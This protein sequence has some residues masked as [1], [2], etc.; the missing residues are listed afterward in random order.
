MHTGKIKRHLAVPAAVCAAVLACVFPARAGGPG[1]AGVQVL[2]SDISPRAA[3]MGGAFVAVADDA[4]AANYNP[5]G[6]AQLYIPEASAMYH[7]GFEDASLQ[8]FTFTMP[9]PIEGLAGFD[10]PGL[11]LSALFSDSGE[12]EYNRIDEGGGVS[13]FS[14]DAESTRV[15]ALTYG[16]KVF[17]GEVN[18]EGYKANIDQYFGLTAKYIGSELLETYSASA[19][20]FDAGWLAR[21]LNSGLAFGA[22][23]S[24]FGSGLRYYQESTPLP[25]ILRVGASYQRP[26][27]MSQSLLLAVDGDIYLE[28]QLKSLRVGLE[29]HFQDM[30]NFRLGYKGMEDNKGMALGLGIHYENFALDFGM[31]L[32]AAVF[33]TTQVAFSYKFAGWRSAEFKK[34]R[35]HQD[36]ALR[37]QDRRAEPAKPAKRAAPA[38]K[39]AAPAKKTKTDAD[40]F[41]IY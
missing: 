33:N 7:S 24:N 3:G 18:L 36:R 41:W 25:T 5:A 30:F 6:V 29:Y 15:V 9:L 28:E 34:S 8:N 37:E 10:N 31:S 39:K 26:T 13:S 14:M 23:V 19:V 40:F 1:S 12:F 11:G 35:P 4:Y 2:K 32:G 16:E 27:V 21:D 22:S 17:S 20:A 38:E